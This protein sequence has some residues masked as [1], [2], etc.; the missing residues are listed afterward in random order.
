MQLFLIVLVVTMRSAPAS[1]ASSDD[2]FAKY[3]ARPSLEPEYV[4]QMFKKY[5]RE[6]TK[7]ST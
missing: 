5:A 1:A 2:I 3:N 6:L 4:E 7:E